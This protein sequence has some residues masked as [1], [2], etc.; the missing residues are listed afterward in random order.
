MDATEYEFASLFR[1]FLA[2]SIDSVITMI[3]VGIPF[4]FVYKESSFFDNPFR[5]V[6]IAML[7]MGC[8][9]LLNFLYHSFLEGLRG[10]TIGK[11]ICGI[12]VLKDDFTKCNIGR[13]FLRNLMRIVDIFF[14]YLVAVV[15]MA[16][17]MK[18]QRLGDIVAE[19]VVVRDRME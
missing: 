12:I 9:L 3:P 7:S 5:F 2:E 1:R 14:Y 18:W 16:G 10:K 4:Y 19:T 17:T 6:A 8:L 11:M 15:L 13:G